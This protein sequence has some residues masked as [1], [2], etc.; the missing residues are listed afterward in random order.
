MAIPRSTTRHLLLLTLLCGA[1]YGAMHRIGDDGGVAMPV[2]RA[3]RALA[4]T[5]EAMEA[6]AEIAPPRRE[7]F[8]QSPQADPFAATSW[9]PPTPPSPPPA[10]A[11]PPAPPSAPPLPFRFVGL[12]EDQARPTAFLS[13]GDALHVVSAGQVLDDVYRIESVTPTEIVITYL[14]LRQRQTL[15]VS[16]A[17]S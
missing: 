13:R 12:L 11:P 5:P 9:L 16:G 14:P 15:P 4:A 2:Q 1:A 17:S 6:P 3:S 7:A 10:K 8:E